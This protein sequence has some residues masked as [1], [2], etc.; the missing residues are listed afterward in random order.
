MARQG[1][2]FANADEV[3]VAKIHHKPG[4]EQGHGG[5]RGDVVEDVPDDGITV[6]EVV[7]RGNIVMKEVSIAHQIPS[8]PIILSGTIVGPGEVFDMQGCIWLEA[9]SVIDS[10]VL[11]R[12]RGDCE[13]V[14]GWLL[15]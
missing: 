11:Q 4:H 10:A 2:A 3:R 8:R 7:V 15:W 13:G 5:D 12:R 1:H 14:Q 9:N 6:G